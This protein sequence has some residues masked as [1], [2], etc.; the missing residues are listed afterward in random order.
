MAV[1]EEIATVTSKGQF[2][3][4][5][6]LRDAMGVSKGMRLV[7]SLDTAG[8]AVM[9]VKRAEAGHEDPAILGFLSVI[10]KD[11]ANGNLF[12]LPTDLENRMRIA[13]AEDI[14]LNEVIEGDVAL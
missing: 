13:A 4:P 2:T 10:E 8:G 1:L 6:P 5:K 3:L 7:C 11:M 9:Q 12:A 14:D